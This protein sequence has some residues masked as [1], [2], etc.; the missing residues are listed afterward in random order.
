M[1]LTHLFLLGIIIL[2]LARHIMFLLA[3]WAYNVFVLAWVSKIGIDSFDS[4]GVSH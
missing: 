3:C 4:S 1:T 2:V